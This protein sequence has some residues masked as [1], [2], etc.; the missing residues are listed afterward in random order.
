MYA[1]SSDAR[2]EWDDVVEATFSIDQC[3]R[4]DYPGPIADLQHRLM[5][6]PREFHGDQRRVSSRLAV[7]PSAAVHEA[8]DRFGNPVASVFARRIERHIEF[9]HRSLVTRTRGEH[10]VP[11]AMLEDEALLRPTALTAC[12]A[13]LRDAAKRL[14]A[15]HAQPMLLATAINA[16]VHA[17]MHYLAGTTV[18]TS[19][20]EA[21]GLRAGVCQDYAHIA[22]ALARRCGLA[23][24]Y[25]SGHLLGEGG[26]HAW[27]EILVPAGS[28]ARVLAYDPT[29][30]SV[31][32]LRYV[33]VAVGRDYADVAPTSGVFTARYNGELTATKTVTVTQV[34][35]CS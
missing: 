4:Y 23:A 5:V 22:L 30:G 32:D 7:A 1:R 13:D 31:V 12:D 10:H 35:Y 25:V 8:L 16:Y 27:I 26:T 21:F 20:V 17:H 33:I 9:D 34:R 6:V 18:E 24:R 3:F 2:I 15:E 28:G 19:A 11:A 29:H 14:Q